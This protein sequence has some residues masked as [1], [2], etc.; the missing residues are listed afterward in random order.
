MSIGYQD[1]QAFPNAVSPNLFPSY[2]QTLAPGVTTTPLVPATA[3]GSLTLR[4]SASAGTAQVAVQ[5]FLDA[6]GT[7][8]LPGDSRSLTPAFAL[9]MTSPIK[10][11]YFRLSINV[12]S[13]GNLTALTYATLQSGFASRISYGN[14]AGLAIINNQSVPA[15][16]SITAANVFT[17][18]GQATCVIVP[19][20]ATGKLFCSVRAITESGALKYQVAQFGN[21]VAGADFQF[22]APDDIL[23]FTAQNTDAAG[24]HSLSA[25]LII[26]PN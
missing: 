13:A 6:A 24:A 16:S 11:P 22:S 9:V 12:T 8:P 14:S 21:P 5:W 18:S 1:Y 3:W 10:G 23:Q 15:S 26:P 4:V 17:M 20:D 19:G 25:T 2:S 7:Q